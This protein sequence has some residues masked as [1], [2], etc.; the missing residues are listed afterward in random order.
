MGGMKMLLRVICKDDG[1][2]KGWWLLLLSY[3][4]EIAK[5]FQ[6]GGCLKI[7]NLAKDGRL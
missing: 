4:W 6:K 2:C 1:G 5:V 3:R 7:S